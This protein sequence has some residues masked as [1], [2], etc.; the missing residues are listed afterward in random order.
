MNF[1]DQLSLFQD[2]ILATYLL[3]SGEC[4]QVSVD[5]GRDQI[6]EEVEEHEG[7]FFVHDRDLVVLDLQ[8]ALFHE[9]LDLAGG[10]FLGD[11]IVVKM[12]ITE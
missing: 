5:E 4:D 6:A 12:L 11:R 9:V 7:T 10:L 3:D 1:F 2:E 8:V